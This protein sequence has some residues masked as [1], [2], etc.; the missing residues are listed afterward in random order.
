MKYLF[1]IILSCLSGAIS[2]R[3]SAQSPS[4]IESPIHKGMNSVYYWK[5]VL[6]LDSTELEF[7]GRHDIGRIYLRLFDVIEDAY[8]NSSQDVTRPDATVRIDYDQYCQLKYN[9]RGMEFVPVVYITLDALKAMKDKEGILARNIVTRVRNMS[10]YNALPNVGELQLDCDWT[11]STEDS[12]FAL[13]DSVKRSIDDLD[14]P[15]KLSSTIR[16]H[17]LARTAPPV[18]KGVLMMYNTGS[19]RNQ[20]TRNSII[21]IKDI[22]P[23]L[24]PLPDYPLHLDIAYPT[25][26]WQLVFRDRNFIGL[27]NDLPLNDTTKFQFTEGRKYVALQDIPHNGKIIRQGDVVRS[28]ISDYKEIKAVKSLIDHHLA[29]R[30]YSDIIYHLDINNLSKYS[31]DEIQGILS[32]H[33]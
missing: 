32:T 24:K 1:P 33:H 30:S 3:Q 13:C 20:N 27:T 23:Y 6:R 19:F 8:S 14:L 31:D 11:K 7:I 4:I 26:S 21:D 29:Q 12:F 16:L 22:E 15:W 28:E 5:T 18:D 10:Q 9:L 17:Q 25:Y 2:C